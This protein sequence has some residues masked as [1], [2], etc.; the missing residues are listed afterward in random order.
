MY[1]YHERER[2]NVSDQQRQAK[3]IENGTF[4]GF[5]LEQVLERSQQKHV[6]FFPSN[7]RAFDGSVLRS[8]SNTILETSVLLDPVDKAD[9][10]DVDFD[11]DYEGD[12]LVLIYDRGEDLC[13]AIRLLLENEDM[14]D[15][16]II[17]LTGQHVPYCAIFPFACEKGQQLLRDFPKIAAF[18][19]FR[20]SNPE[21]LLHCPFL[22]F[23]YIQIVLTP[24]FLEGLQSYRGS[25]ALLDTYAVAALVDAL[26]MPNVHLKELRYRHN[27]DVEDIQID[28][29]RV[30]T[31][32]CDV[33][34]FESMEPNSLETAALIV[35]RVPNLVL[36]LS[37]DEDFSHSVSEYRASVT[38]ALDLTHHDNVQGFHWRAVQDE[39]VDNEFMMQL[40][41][42]KIPH[43]GQV[44]S[45]T[46]EMD[47][48]ISRYVLRC[49]LDAL[50]PAPCQEL[51]LVMGEPHN[52]EDA[53]AR[54]TQ[55]AKFV[56]RNVHLVKFDC[57]RLLVPEED[58]DLEQN[59]YIEELVKDN[60]FYRGI[61]QHPMIPLQVLLEGR[62]SRRP[63]MLFDALRQ[64]AN[65]LA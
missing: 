51:E 48:P 45:L 6:T 35:D 46:L 56:R 33:F 43:L 10:C 12:R 49:M 44:E 55:L 36:D 18:D 31:V 50:T 21:C 42:T 41:Q 16:M 39:M 64:R 9:L 25:L 19:N 58:E 47:V 11:E 29:E 53:E 24:Q 27:D 65:D 61:R 26:H 5:G 30:A 37:F 15:A 34:V 32:S 28:A 38:Q 13:D 1:I 23:Y 62:T 17:R 20:I 2:K 40:C 22:A 8:G 54:K 59:E 52:A 14:D 4:T 60:A 3:A 63:G 57:E 7:V